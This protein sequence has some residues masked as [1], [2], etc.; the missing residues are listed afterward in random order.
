MESK[1][2]RYSG[3]KIIS[4]QKSEEILAE[5]FFKFNKIYKATNSRNSM[6]PKQKR[7]RKKYN[8]V[9]DINS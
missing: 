4:E 3:T 6:N 7:K 9:I 5:F 1:V 8:S 2:F